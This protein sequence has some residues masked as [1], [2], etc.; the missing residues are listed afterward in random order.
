MKF[1]FPDSQDQVYP[2]FDF[3]SEEMSRF[4]VRQRDDRYAHETLAHPAYDGMLVSKGIVDGYGEKTSRYS[5]A[6]RQR[7]Y[8]V[9]IREFFRLDALEN[10]RRMHTMGDCGAFS[11]LREETPPFTPDEV[12][13]FYEECG[14]DEGASIDHV[15]LGFDRKCDGALEGFGEV[16]EDWKRRQ[17]ITLELAREFKHRHRVRKSKIEPLG[18]AQGWSPL[19]YA[20]CVKELQK[21]GYRRIGLGGMV[22][23]PTHD[24]LGCLHAISEI[25]KP[26]TQIHLFG[27]TRVDTISEFAKLGV[28]SFD[29]TSPFRQAFKDNS[30]NFHMLQKKYTALRVPQVHKNTKMKRQILAGEIDQAAAVLLEKK[31]LSGLRRV[32][33]GDQSG[34]SGLVELLCEYGRL[35]GDKQDRAESY[36]EI[37]QDRPWESCDCGICEQVGINVAIFRGSERNKRRGFHNLHVFRKS[38]TAEGIVSEMGASKTG[39]EVGA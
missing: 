30:D 3:D 13:D 6:Q 18:A 16:F 15:I 7:L 19:S 2:Y 1:F 5:M 37:L 36:S 4:R 27:V 26:S 23:L 9:G 20:S 38:M 39:I 14:F 25:R 32:G 22:A 29:S 33:A 24:I 34:L 21:M 28:S 8:R 12:L 35:F 17:E 11:Y 10:S 31:C